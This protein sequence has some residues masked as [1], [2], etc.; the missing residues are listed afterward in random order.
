MPTPQKKVFGTMVVNDPLRRLYFLGRALA[1][2]RTLKFHRGVSS[3]GLSA[4]RTAARKRACAANASNFW[5]GIFSAWVKK[6]M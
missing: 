1:L 3:P 4:R 2:G 6:T 5:S